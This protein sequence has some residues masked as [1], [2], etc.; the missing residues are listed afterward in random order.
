MK[1]RI[2]KL[3]IGRLRRLRTI[4]RAYRRQD[5]FLLGYHGADFMEEA[6]AADPRAAVP[7]FPLDLVMAAPLTREDRLEALRMMGWHE[8]APVKRFKKVYKGP[9]YPTDP[10]KELERE[11]EE[12]AKVIG[13]R[14]SCIGMPR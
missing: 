10:Q 14:T 1:A 2:K 9:G 8:P 5:G 11:S 3:Y 4:A 7:M 6:V 13:R 12:L